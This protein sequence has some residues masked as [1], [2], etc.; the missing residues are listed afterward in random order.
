MRSSRRTKT[1]Y[2]CCLLPTRFRP[3][4]IAVVP[5]AAIVAKA[6]SASAAILAGFGFIDLQGAT[7]KFLAIELRNCWSGFF[8]AGHFDEGKA[9]R[10]SSVAVFHNTGRLN[11]ASLAKQ[12]LQLLTGSLASEV[13]H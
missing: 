4:S 8:L 2:Y 6:M 5:T 1:A 11:G 3:A 9:S 12:L 13:S 7:T 10:A